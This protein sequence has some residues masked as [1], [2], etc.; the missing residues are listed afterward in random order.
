MD[1]IL[2]PTD[3]WIFK[4][5][6]GDERNKSMLIDLLKSFVDLPDEEYELTFLDTYLKPES[7]DDKLGIVD[8][9]V[10]TKTGKI[11]DIEIQINKM[12]HIGKRLSFYKS[13]LIVEQIGKSELYSV[14]QKVI[15]IC[16]TNYELFPM[17]MDYLNNFRFYN[18]KNEL[19]F[20]DIPEEVY[21]LEL[22]KVPSR[23]DGTTGWEWMQFLR[24]KR[25]EDFEMIA[26]KNPEIRK[27]VNTLYELSADEKVRA[28]YETRQKAWRDRM[29][30]NEGYYR[31]GALKVLDL[32][33]SG[34]TPEEAM[35]IL[36]L[37]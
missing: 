29:S 30:Q 21:T 26:A 2:P 11:I 17:V 19:C 5:L 36:G 31:E 23:S 14:I 7:E 6:F 32:I 27:A 1:E 15:C 12:K 24:A 28:E 13:K 22:S 8:V 4:L 10:Q 9:K 25:K 33:K 20:E 35:D 3:D 37:Q 16:I 18:K 34:K